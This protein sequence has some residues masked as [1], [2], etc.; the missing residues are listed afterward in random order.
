MS[1]VGVAEADGGPAPGASAGAAD[2]FA[3]S[4]NSPKER[5]QMEGIALQEV[6]FTNFVSTDNVWNPIVVQVADGSIIWTV[7]RHPHNQRGDASTVEARK[8]SVNTVGII[9]GLRG[10]AWLI[11][12]DD[13]R[14]D[15]AW[16]K[17]IQFYHVLHW[18]TLLEGAK[19]AW[20]ADK[21]KDKRVV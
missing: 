3:D 1:I 15:P 6:V 9:Q 5:W 12:R 14:Q 2:F 19:A 4:W 13:V 11:P 21:K 7:S 20:D 16:G 18:A 17:T 8:E 10:G